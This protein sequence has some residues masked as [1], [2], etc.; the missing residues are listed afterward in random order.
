MA[1]LRDAADLDYSTVL[2]TLEAYLG[3]DEADAGPGVLELTYES[4]RGLADDYCN[5][6][7]T[8]PADPD[9]PEDD[10]DYSEVDIPTPSEVKLGVFAWTQHLLDRSDRR[11]GTSIKTGDLS[12]TYLSPTMSLDDLQRQYLAG[13]RL[14]PGLGLDPITKTRV[15]RYRRYY[16]IGRH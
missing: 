15:Q 3:I 11:G 13:W 16:S 10:P 5:N 8:E 14:V 9:V 12:V 6:P 4:A 2:P 1:R 7:F